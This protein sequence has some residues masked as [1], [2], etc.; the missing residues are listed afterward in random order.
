L[1]QD[2]HDQRGAVIDELRR[3]EE[4]A[5]YSSKGHFNAAERWKSLNFALGVPAA[6]MS[7]LAG[8]SALSQFDHHNVV[9]GVLAL[10][11]A[12]VTAVITFLNPSEQSVTH[13]GFGNRY[14][15]LKNRCRVAAN[16]DSRRMDVDEL[17]QR[18][19]ELSAERDQLGADA[20]GIPRWAFTRA[21]RGIEQGEAQYTI[22]QG[23]SSSGK[24]G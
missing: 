5:V 8:A 11:V 14:N 21:R 2:I 18:L 9:A 23:G 13:K 22:D 1:Q 7:G 10:V 6:V 3:V 16:V 4:D 15:A 24:D 17:R 12:A 19:D 20:P